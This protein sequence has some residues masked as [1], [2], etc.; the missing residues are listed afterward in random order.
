[1]AKNENTEKTT[2]ARRTPREIALAESEKA[3][4]RLE[5]ARKRADKAAAEFEAARAEMAAALRAADYASQHPDLAEPDVDN[6]RVVGE[7]V[8]AIDPND[9][10][11]V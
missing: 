1:M 10:G 6:D 5:K 3:T 9:P 2:R 11:Q 7:D 8:E 4:A